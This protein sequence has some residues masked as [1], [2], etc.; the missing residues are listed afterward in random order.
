MP[1]TIVTGAQWGDEGKGRIVDLLS[2]DSDFVV[3]CQGG[4]NA[5]HTIINEQGRFVLHTVPSGI[6]SRSCRSVIGPGAVISPPGLT[7][8]MKALEGSGVDIGNILISDRAHVILPYHQL[9]ER[10]EEETRSESARIGST[11]QGVGPAYTDKAARLGIRAGELMDMAFLKRRLDDILPFKNKILQAVYGLP[12]LTT[13]EIMDALE[14]DAVYLRPYIRETSAVLRNG[15][16]AGKRVLLEGQ[17]G[18]MRDLDWGAYP[19]VTSSCPSPAGM[20]AGAGLPP[21]GVERIVGVAKVYTTAVG[22]GPFPTEAFGEEADWLRAQG[23]EY[24]ATTGRPRRC[25]WFD[26]PA[27]RWACDAA[28]FTELAL[29]KLDVLTDLD[30][31]PICAEY[32]DSLQSGSIGNPGSGAVS[33]TYKHFDGWTHDLW[34]ARTIDDLPD[35]ARK[36]ITA[37]EMMVNI[38]VS[39][40]SVGPE[41]SEIVTMRK[42]N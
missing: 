1:L 28:G 26:G 36:Y 35:T 23:K 25:G 42:G 34:T 22:A 15:L 29:T 16:A 5:G 18:M 11:G 30:P 17:L 37:I 3:R 7:A 31:I 4:P 10:L 8:E 13:A 32:S 20:V 2:Q 24:G 27:V 38:P 6:F 9:I 41:R 12:P 33:P 40:V 39:M 14:S 19:F 21:M